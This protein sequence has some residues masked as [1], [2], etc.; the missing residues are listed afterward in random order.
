MT[1][2]NAM[3]AGCP[4]SSQPALHDDRQINALMPV[5]RTCS[6]CGVPIPPEATAG[7]C[8]KCLI[9]LA[10]TLREEVSEQ[11]DSL[12]CTD[13]NV[14]ETIRLNTESLRAGFGDYEFLN[15]GNQGGMGI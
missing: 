1:F 4:K 13:P 5:G 7:E 3:R 15:Q 2:A 6:I 11:A 10:E 8:A 14:L 12:T 9:G